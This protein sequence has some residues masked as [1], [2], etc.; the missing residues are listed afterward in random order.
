L[1]VEEILRNQ[2]FIALTTF[3]KNGQ[4]VTRP[5]FFVFDRDKIFFYTFEKYRKVRQLRYNPNVEIAPAKARMGAPKNYKI[6]GKTIEGVARLLEGEEAETA[7]RLLR[8]KYGFKYTVFN[9]LR[10]ISLR[11]SRLLF[12]EV[13]PKVLTN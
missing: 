13:T 2:N 3:K 10:G 12:Y 7:S 1:T 9:I 11:G 6:I 5:V 4:G 8:K